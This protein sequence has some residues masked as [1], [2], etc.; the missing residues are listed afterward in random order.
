[1]Y[2]LTYGCSHPAFY[3]QTLFSSSCKKVAV[4]IL[5]GYKSEPGF[6]CK[7]SPNCT[8]LKPREQSLILVVLQCH[9]SLLRLYFPASLVSL[10]FF[11]VTGSHLL[12]SSKAE[13]Q[14]ITTCSVP[15]P[16]SSPRWPE[17]MPP[18]RAARWAGRSAPG[19]QRWEKREEEG[20][21][22]HAD[23]CMK[24]A[25]GGRQMKGSGRWLPSVGVD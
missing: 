11:Q 9:C 12:V 24:R 14:N 22:R 13:T 6:R 10:L 23:T 19:A 8:Q 3:S 16:L 17:R 18:E 2:C 7:L 21:G 1:M 25:V 20:L 5:Q 15:S 4:D